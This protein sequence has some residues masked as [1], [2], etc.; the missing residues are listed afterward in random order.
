MH[1]NTSESSIYIQET[2]QM[3]LR[4]LLLRRRDAA[5]PN[6]QL[7]QIADD[8]HSE[9]AKALASVH[10]ERVLLSTNKIQE[11]RSTT[12]TLFSSRDCDM[13]TSEV[14]RVLYTHCSIALSCIAVFDNPSAASAASAIKLLDEAMII[15]GAPGLIDQVQD[16]I[17]HIQSD[18][19]SFKRA[20]QPFVCPAPTKP[21]D[22]PS[23]AATGCSITRLPQ[24]PTL[25]DFLVSYSAAPFVV[26]QALCDWPALTTHPWSSNQYLREVAGPGRVVPVEIGNDYR[27]DEGWS[28]TLMP[29]EEFLGHLEGETHHPIVYLAQ[30]SLL[31]QFP[32]LRDDVSI[33]DLVYYSPSSTDPHYGPPNNDE[34][35]VINAWLGPKGTL[36]PAHKV[37]VS[38]QLLFCCCSSCWQDPFFNCYGKDSTNCDSSLH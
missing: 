4:D 22:L 1:K 30:H 9:I 14:S 5:W 6:R 18:L 11:Q 27:S 21:L 23:L 32:R 13:S 10:D 24:I 17:D 34:G 37:Y 2:L 16:L 38:S 35:L 36:S 26:S 25:Q 20:F 29:W 28:A 8:L 15:A 33:P 12:H 3:A 19:L 31:T 7:R